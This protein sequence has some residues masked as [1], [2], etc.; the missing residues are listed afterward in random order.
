MT[1]A[2]RP[3]LTRGQPAPR[4]PLSADAAVLLERLAQTN[5]HLRGVADILQF[6]VEP[7]RLRGSA[8]AAKAIDTAVE[9][10]HNA[11]HL[12]D[13]AISRAVKE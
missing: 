7:L 10:L 3:I 4:P 6:Y 13:L 5:R 8:D 12:N 2:P 11:A 9:R 1:D